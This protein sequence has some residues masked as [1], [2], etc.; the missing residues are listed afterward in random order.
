MSDISALNEDGMTTGDQKTRCCVFA[1]VCFQHTRYSCGLPVDISTN[2]TAYAAF[3]YNLGPSWNKLMMRITPSNL[4][5]STPSSRGY[6][7]GTCFYE[8]R[9]A[10]NYGR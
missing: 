8:I 6:T 10:E 1:L 9:A 3:V 2:D 7:R 4:L 5:Q